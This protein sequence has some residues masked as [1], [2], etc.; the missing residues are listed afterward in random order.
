VENWAGPLL[1]QPESGFACVKGMG[2]ATFFWIR[3]SFEWDKKNIEERF[4]GFPQIKRE[5]SGKAFKQ[6][7]PS[8]SKKTIRNE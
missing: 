2:K 5:K 8:S 7:F 3:K 1:K 4:G 6:R